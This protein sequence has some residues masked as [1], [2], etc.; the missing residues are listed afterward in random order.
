MRVCF[1]LI[2]IIFSCQLHAQLDDKTIYDLKSGRVLND[3]SYVYWLPVEK[4]KKCFLIQAYNSKMSHKNELSLD[5][6]LKKGT[7][8]YAAREG[9]VEEVKDDSDEGGLRDEYL[10]KGNHIIIRQPDGSKAMYWHLQK[11]GVQV[12][13]GDTIAKGQLIGLS[14]NT[15]YTAFP[16]LHFEVIDKNGRQIPT[17]FL[18]KKGIRY[19]R[20]AKWYRCTWN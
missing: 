5:F 7:R 2:L 13:I 17:R 10:S 3:N 20:P 4:G 18:T 14:G 8:I 19:L 15:G 12:K 16:H 6:K 9:V 11:N 1:S